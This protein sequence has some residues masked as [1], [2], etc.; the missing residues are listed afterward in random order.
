MNAERLA[1]L[2]AIVGHN[3]PNVIEQLREFHQFDDSVLNPNDKVILGISRG[4]IRCEGECPCDQ[5][6]IPLEDKLCPC[7]Q[8]RKNK[9]CKCNLF[10]K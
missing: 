5:G 2:T 8:Y 10:I 6:D 9:I 4:L 3:D 7:V 1:E